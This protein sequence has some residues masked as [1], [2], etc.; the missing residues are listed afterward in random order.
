MEKRARFVRLAALLS[1]GLTVAAGCTSADQ[2]GPASSAA[3]VVPEQTTSTETEEQSTEQSTTSQRAE[4]R[5]WS[6]LPIC[7]TELVGF[8]I[9]GELSSVGWIA[10]AQIDRASIGLPSD[11]DSILDLHASLSAEHLVANGY[12]T[13][14]EQI[15]ARESIS[16]YPT[17][18]FQVE[19]GSLRFDHPDKSTGLVRAGQARF[20]AT[21]TPDGAS[22]VLPM[23]DRAREQATTAAL[24][25][26]VDAFEVQ[27]S[28]DDLE[29]IE[30]SLAA[31]VPDWW[32][33]TD[34]RFNAVT[35]DLGVDE[36]SDEDRWPF[37]EPPDGVC[38]LIG[39]RIG[40]FGPQP[41]AG[42]GW[43]LLAIAETGVE[44]P[45]PPATND[46]ELA[47]LWTDLEIPDDVPDIDFAS[48]VVTTFSELRG[49]RP[50]CDRVIFDGVAFGDSEVA[51][52]PRNVDPIGLQGCLA[53]GIPR[54]FVVALDRARLPNGPFLL[55][56]DIEP[57]S[58]DVDREQI[59]VDLTSTGSA[60]AD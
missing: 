16:Y 1:A 54:S 21:M 48:E 15:A 30:A 38:R 45:A 18:F 59:T 25:M 20:V 58:Y 41:A 14:D 13:E 43:R 51:G 55:R 60:T 6:A 44:A 52:M 22:T 47:A 7:G 19:L 5:G 12:R 53:I 23:I 42:D 26:D 11:I 36:P 49:F 35:V 46:E 31:R 9:D 40:D 50:S 39:D 24:A 8:D 10:S 3:A 56:R 33:F 17:P 32:L 4:P 2:G 29:A 27:H 34:R 37:A 28:Q 57:S